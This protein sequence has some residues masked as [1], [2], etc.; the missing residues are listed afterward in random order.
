MISKVETEP[1]LSDKVESDITQSE[2]VLSEDVE[3]QIV[4]D[5]ILSEQETQVR[6]EPINKISDP[7]I[8]TYTI[9]MEL[10]LKK[11]LPLYKYR[12]KLLNILGGDLS[13]QT[14]IIYKFMNYN[15]GENIK[16][17]DIF[18]NVFRNYTSENAVEEKN[19]AIQA[20]YNN[21]KE[22]GMIFVDCF[23]LE[24]LLSAGNLFDKDI[25]YNDVADL[26]DTV[27]K[28]YL[29]GKVKQASI[30]VI[31]LLKLADDIDRL[32]IIKSFFE[33]I[34]NII[35]D[36]VSLI[37]MLPYVSVNLLTRV[38]KN[39]MLERVANIYNSANKDQRIDDH[40]LSIW[41][42]LSEMETKLF[43]IP[44]HNISEYTSP[45]TDVYSKYEPLSQ[46]CLQN[47]DEI[48][49]MIRNKNPISVNSDMVN[50]LERCRPKE[51]K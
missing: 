35:F 22:Y 9:S 21:I 36:D 49:N 47:I 17:K 30:M 37:S 39:M 19:T 38:N 5:T 34:E 50:S 26:S 11:Q 24:F 29:D 42:Y 51:I 16:L 23:S 27:S 1:V 45:H 4:T 6:E 2:T 3:P 15:L 14:N 25:A 32:Y 40:K 10:E 28:L 46:D 7:I 31:V 43:K 8:D 48:K 13:N 18:I 20:L 12:D 33:R 44:N 41:P